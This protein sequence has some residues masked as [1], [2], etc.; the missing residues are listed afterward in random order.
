MDAKGYIE[1]SIAIEPCLDG[2]LYLFFVAKKMNNKN[3]LE[4]TE[5]NLLEEIHNLS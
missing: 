4:H 5:Q 1:S 3:L 2:Y